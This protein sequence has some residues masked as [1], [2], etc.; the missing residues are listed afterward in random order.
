MT[1]VLCEVSTLSKLSACC[2]VFTTLSLMMETEKVL[3]M[4]MQLIP[5]QY[6]AECV[7]HER[8]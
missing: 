4:L 1:C 6:F 8:L 3:N 5:P 7:C 2:L